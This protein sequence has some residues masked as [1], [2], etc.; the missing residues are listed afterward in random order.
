MRTVPRSALR[1]LL[2][3]VVAVVVGLSGVSTPATAHEERESVFPAGDDQQLAVELHRVLDD[4]AHRRR[5][6]AA[7]LERAAGFGPER[8]AERLL[9]A[10][11]AA[12]TGR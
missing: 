4:D 12:L 2:V 10:Y 11:R 9:A 3:L 1:L 8:T 7:G 6:V 5:L